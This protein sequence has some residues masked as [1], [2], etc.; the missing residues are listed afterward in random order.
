MVD[1]LFHLGPAIQQGSSVIVEFR[2]LAVEID[3][4]HVAPDPAAHFDQAQLVAVHVG[5]GVLAGAADMG[6]RLQLAFQV[7]AP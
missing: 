1:R 4:D 7:V 6:R 5:M 3:E 2:C